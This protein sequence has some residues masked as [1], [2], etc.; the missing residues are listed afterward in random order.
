MRRLID[1]GQPGVSD[2]G[3]RQGIQTWVITRI[4]A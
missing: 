1:K 3:Q 4:D 2:G